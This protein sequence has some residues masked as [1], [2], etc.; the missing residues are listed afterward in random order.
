M[1]PV[2]IIYENQ[3]EIHNN[4]I[5]KL[6][7]YLI[8]LKEAYLVGSLAEG[9]FGQYAE[10]YE[11]YKGSDIDIVA[12]PIKIHIK[13][14]YQGDFYGWHKKY[15]LDTIKIKEIEHPVNFMVPFNN[16]IDLFWQKVKELNWKVERLI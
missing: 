14:Q 1:K 4:I 15:Q 5:R 13:W 10:E 6:K 9:K 2:K 3:E 12:I 11:G 7:P 8:D 16:N